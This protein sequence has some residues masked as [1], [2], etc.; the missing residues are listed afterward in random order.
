MRLTYLATALLVALCPA[1]AASPALGASESERVVFSAA[2]DIYAARI[3]TIRPDG[4][5]LARL[6]DP[7]DGTRDL[8]PVWS[9]SRQRI[10]FV[11]GIKVGENF[12]GDW[13]FRERLVVMTSEGEELFNLGANSH[14]PAWSPDGAK[15]AFLRGYAESSTIWTVN[16]DGQDARRA[17]RGEHPAWS[18]DGRR[19]AFERWIDP[20][21]AVFVIDADGTSLRRLVPRTQLLDSASPAWSPDGRRIALIGQTRLYSGD[22]SGLYI[23]TPN[24]RGLIRIVPPVPMTSTGGP[25]WSP[26]GRWLTF[27]REDVLYRIGPTGRGVKPLV[28][29]DPH[30]ADWSPN[31]REVAFTKF[32]GR[33]S[34]IYAV[35]STGSSVRPITPRMRYLGQ[36]DW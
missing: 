10:A 36:F 19:I 18:P 5:G 22:G 9:P 17:T 31:G 29:G 6:T 20:E 27:N 8:D 23:V 15:L 1:G 35:T 30:G 14:S 11:R 21:T 24:G 16:R 7:G 32:G 34:R 13:I 4:S 26:D 2:D 12:R 28:R 25:E 3:Y 33:G